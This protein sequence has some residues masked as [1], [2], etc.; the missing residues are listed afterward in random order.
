[1]IPE[2]LRTRL[3]GYAF[4]RTQLGRVAETYRLRSSGRPT[5]YLKIADD[6]AGEHARLS[7]AAGKLPVP[8]VIGCGD[9]HL[10]LG[11][12]P[13]TPAELATSPPIDQLVALMRQLHALPVADCPFDARVPARLA[14]AE[15]N[16]RAGI[17]DETDFD[18]DRRGRSAASVLAELRAWPAFEE[19][20][21]VTHGDFSLANLLVDPPG[22]LDLGRLGVGDRHADLALVLRDLEPARGEELI[23]AYGVQVDARKLA[24]YRVLDELF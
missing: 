17:V 10:L 23:A 22:M 4:E 11:E 12:L 13:G 24:F 21:V 6:L 7:W 18:D 14:Q 16:V 3:A 15:A 20:L 8:S 2:G 9:D 5:L 1:M 19:E